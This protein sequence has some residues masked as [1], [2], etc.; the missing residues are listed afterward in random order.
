M[1]RNGL[2]PSSA[3]KSESASRRKELRRTVDRLF[4]GE[5]GSCIDDEP[6]LQCRHS[7]V[8]ALFK[9]RARANE[10]ARPSICWNGSAVRPS[11]HPMARQRPSQ[12]TS[13]GRRSPG[14]APCFSRRNRPPTKQRTDT[15]TVSNRI[16]PKHGESGRSPELALFSRAPDDIERKH[17]DRDTLTD[18]VSEVLTPPA[19]T[20][21][22]DAGASSASSLTR[23]RFSRAFSSRPPSHRMIPKQ[24]S[25]RVSTQSAISAA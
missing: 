21:A 9:H 16:G 25:T 20:T 3:S 15:D 17:A 8:D 6:L 7:L 2:A 22:H 12:T 1:H 5:C 13:R 24:R 10:A 18:V 4:E 14:P 11:S 23:R 19:P